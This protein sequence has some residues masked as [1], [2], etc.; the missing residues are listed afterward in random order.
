MFDGVEN[1]RGL[2]YPR[3]RV[4]EKKNKNEKPTENDGRD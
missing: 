2:F 4:N 3:V 1:G